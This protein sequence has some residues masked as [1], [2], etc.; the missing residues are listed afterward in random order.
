[1]DKKWS[2]LEKTNK[3]I[4]GDEGLIYKERLTVQCVLAKVFLKDVVVD[5]L[6]FILV[7][8]F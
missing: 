6:F 4:L 5:S 8:I 1:V 3:N 2:S 7:H